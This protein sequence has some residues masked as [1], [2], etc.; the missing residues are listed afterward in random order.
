MITPD[1]VPELLSDAT[2][3]IL[4]AY[5]KEVRKYNESVLLS[6]FALPCIH[7]VRPGGTGANCPELHE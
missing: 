1:D 4:C 2:L 3:T 7:A 6:R 5:N